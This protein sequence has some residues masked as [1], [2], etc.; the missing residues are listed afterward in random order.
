MAIFWWG[1]PSREC[2]SRILEFI[3]KHYIYILFRVVLLVDVV[4]GLLVRG[5]HCVVSVFVV[6]HTVLSSRVTFAGN[7]T[8]GQPSRVRQ[9]EGG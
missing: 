2:D 8:W 4:L 6:V 9:T 7:S 1:R 3:G 5:L